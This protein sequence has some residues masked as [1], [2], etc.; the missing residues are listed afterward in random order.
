[1]I[2]NLSRRERRIIVAGAI[3]TVLAGGWFGV[4]KPMRDRQ[5]G[6]NELL[7]VREQ[8]LAGRQELVGR[9]AAIATELET[10]SARLEALGTRFLPAATPAVAASELQKLVK[11]M[12]AL[13]V[14]EVR[15]ERILPP[16]ERGELLEIPLEITFSGDIRQLVDLLSRLDQAP[17]LLAVQDIRVRVVN[18]SQPKDLLATLT[19]SGFIL[20]GKART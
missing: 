13:A 18:I 1:M 9:K 20:P 16:V 11:E 7:P 6:A 2:G 17:K 5:R 8:L 4:L 15:S 3:L 10:T 19:L 12:A 14:T